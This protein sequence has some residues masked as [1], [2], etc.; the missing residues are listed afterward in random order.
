MAMLVELISIFLI[1]F[2]I[3]LIPFASPSNLLIASSMALLVDSD[4]FS[5]G[6][7]VALGATCAKLVHY[8]ISFFVGEHVSEKD[9][10]RLER[11][12]AKTRRW[13]ALAVFVVAATPVPDDPVVVPLGLMKYS[14]TKFAVSYFGGK[15]LITVI[16]AFLGG[17]SEQFLSGYV[18]QVILA[19]VSIALTIVVTVALLRIDL[20]RI[21]EKILKKI[22]WER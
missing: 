9:K 15:L 4:P 2:G 22:G 3:N 20:S 19:I 7:S 16:G 6:V 21:G 1:T 17:F 5:I 13:A 18:S 12:G 10:E 14:P 11:V 8:A